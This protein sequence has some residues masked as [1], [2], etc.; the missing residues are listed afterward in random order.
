[1]AYEHRSEP[2]LHWP[3]FL[4]RLARSIIVGAMLILVSLLVGMVGYH[5]LEKLDCIDSYVNA[6]MILSGMGPL[7][8]PVTTAGKFFAGT[9]ALY[10]GIAVLAIAG[11]VFAPVVHRFLHAL[12]AEH[13]ESGEVR[14][15]R[16][17]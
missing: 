16:G 13:A 2:L 8:N 11:V 5:S 14:R 10:S 17:P 7:H 1:M 15:A 3:R 9:Y 4:R 12:H 6:A